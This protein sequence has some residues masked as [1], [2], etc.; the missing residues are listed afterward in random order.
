MTQIILADNLQYSSYL[1]LAHLWWVTVHF[2]F[3]FIK[4]SAT[5]KPRWTLAGELL[6]DSPLTK[7]V[8]GVV[9]LLSSPFNT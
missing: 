3:P 5:H 4:L 7:G 6:Q 8:E 9:T 1:A 2:S